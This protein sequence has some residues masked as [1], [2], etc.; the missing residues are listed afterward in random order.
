[1][2]SASMGQVFFLTVMRVSYQRFEEKTSFILLFFP[3]RNAFLECRF[4]AFD[5]FQLLGYFGCANC[6][7]FLTCAF[8]P[9]AESVLLLVVADHFNFLWASRAFWICFCTS[10]I[11]LKRPVR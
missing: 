3:I 11:S 2:E 1:M 9:F 5:A 8:D 4:R 6:I 10:G 7:A